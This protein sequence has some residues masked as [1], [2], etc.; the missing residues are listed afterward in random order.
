MIT[1]QLVGSD[2]KEGDVVGS[3]PNVATNIYLYDG[4]GEEVFDIVLSICV[5]LYNLSSEAI[6]GSVE[7]VRDTIASEIEEPTRFW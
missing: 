6:I 4:G 3:S 1:A 2:A 7:G 5:R